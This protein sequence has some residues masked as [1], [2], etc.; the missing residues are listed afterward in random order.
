MAED[1]IEAIFTASILLEEKVSKYYYLLADL[2][3]DDASFL[4]ELAREE[5]NHSVLIGTVKALYFENRKYFPAEAICPKLSSI[6]NTD[7]KIDRLMA[8]YRKKQPGKKEAF[9]AA[10]KIEKSSVEIFFQL[11]AVNSKDS[12]GLKIFRHIVGADKDHVK[13]IEERMRAWVSE[14]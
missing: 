7:K 11:A 5:V 14:V 9:Q 2:F 1:Y 3:K 12:P 4:V 13:R 8:Q 10:I 6:L